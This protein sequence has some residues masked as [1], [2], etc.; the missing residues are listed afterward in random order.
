MVLALGGGN[1]ILPKVHDKFR[2]IPSQS[3]VIYSQHGIFEA[4]NE[5]TEVILG[6]NY[7]LPKFNRI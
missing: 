5:V 3:S 2:E 4:K 6:G 7:H 1:G